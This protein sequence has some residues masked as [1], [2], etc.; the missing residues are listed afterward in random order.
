M[1]TQLQHIQEN[2]QYCKGRLQTEK[3]ESMRLQIATEGERL[4]RLLLEL[5]NAEPT[6]QCCS[7]CQTLLPIEEFRKVTSH[8]ITKQGHKRQTTARRSYC[9]RCHNKQCADSNRHRVTRKTEFN[10]LF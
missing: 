9:K 1:R 6:E 8:Y 5:K 4:N 2:I 10:Y 3:N 7:K